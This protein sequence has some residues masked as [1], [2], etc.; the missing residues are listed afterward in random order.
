MIEKDNFIYQS[1]KF[2]DIEI[3][4]YRVPGF[5]ELSL[6]QK[7]LAY[8]LYEAALSGRNI[9]YDQHYKE[10]LTIKNFIEIIV[11]YYTGNR[12][13]DEFKKFMTYAKRVW[14][15]NG[16]HH[17]YSMKKILPDFSVENMIE[18]VEHTS[19]PS[20]KIADIRIVEQYIEMLVP[21]IFNSDVAARRVN[22]D[23][24]SDVI[25]TSANNFYEGFTAFTL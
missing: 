22:L 8:Y 23:A 14:F 18:F 20:I 16:I 7:E 21:L 25:L 5:E 9:L 24:N 11:K 2:A 12:E 13:T 3:L 1:E 17:H 10:N 6:K 19:Q 15:S 4:R